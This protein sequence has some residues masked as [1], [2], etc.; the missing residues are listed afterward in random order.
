MNIV[1][2][3]V[4]ALVLLVCAYFVYLTKVDVAPDTALVDGKLRA[5]AATPNC[6]SSE[7]TGE[8]FVEPISGSV[9]MDELW[10]AA[11]TAVVAQGGIV[12]SSQPT[13]FWATFESK[14]F[15]FT[16]DFELRRD[17]ETGVVQVRSS[18]RSGKSDLGVNRK[19]VEAIRAAIK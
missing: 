1:I 5:C 16:D 10:Q 3:I 2:S 19:R 12:Q 17:D 7:T 14:L 4:L 11:Q 9:A 8:K 13:H 6:V 18:S 15:K